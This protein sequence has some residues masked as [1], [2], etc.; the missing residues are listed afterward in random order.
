MLFANLVEATTQNATIST[1]SLVQSG[2]ALLVHAVDVL[3]ASAR[4]RLRGGYVPSPCPPNR[5]QMGT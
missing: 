1:L 3:E 4:P 2:K 5:F